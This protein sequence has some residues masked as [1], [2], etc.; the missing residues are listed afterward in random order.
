MIA[1]RRLVLGCCLL[2]ASAAAGSPPAGK[3]T[4][5]EPFEDEHKYLTNIVQLTRQEMGFVNAGEAYFSPD[6]KSIIFQATPTGQSDYQ[7]YTMDLDTA[8]TRMVS[9][10]KGACTCAF[11]HPSG[12]KIIFASTHLAPEAT[13]PDPEKDRDDYAWKFHEHMDIF[14]ANPDG[15]DLKQLTR[16]PGYDAEGSYSADGKLI[17]FT[18]KRDG[19]LEVYVMNAD[20]AHPRRLTYGNG[21]DGGPF[22][23][24]DGS[25]ILYRGD[26]RNDGKM[27]LQLR[28][29]QATG[30]GDRAITDNAVF[31]WCPYWYPDGSS[32]IFTQTD[33][34]AY[35]RGEKPNYD[36]YMTTTRGKEF[37]RITFDPAFDGLPVFSPDGERLM[38]TSKRGG[39]NEAQIFFAD[40]R[41]PKS[42][43]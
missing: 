24:P 4:S 41:L 33:H 21:Y 29:V 12:K 42:L 13:K 11:F 31:N 32:F 36:L 38:W 37:T 26:R 23:S 19:D 17:V 5:L 7:I 20:G 15:S 43:E 2:V 14:E 25:R 28:I 40:F 22:F 35:T 16:S 1:L 6:M 30:K 18:S 27:N 8:A 10:G 9:T 34:A 3:A 39:L